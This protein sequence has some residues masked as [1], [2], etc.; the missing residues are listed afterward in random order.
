[1]P[2]RPSALIAS[3]VRTR[4]RDGARPTWPDDNTAGR[5]ICL[6][7]EFDG[8]DFEYRGDAFEHIDRRGV[9]FTLQHS[10]IV[11][12]DTCTIG[13]LLLRQALGMTHLTQIRGD[14]LPPAHRKRTRLNSSH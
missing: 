11:A 6:A 1:M 2:R 13:K 14:D 4:K 3:G 9:F 7:E 10:D 5:S 12:V 8:I